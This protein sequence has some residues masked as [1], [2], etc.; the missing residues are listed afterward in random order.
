MVTVSL[1]NVLSF[2]K[3]LHF[4]LQGPAW[5]DPEDEVKQAFPPIY[6]LGNMLFAK[7]PSLDEKID[8]IS[9][10]VIDARFYQ[11]LAALQQKINEIRQGC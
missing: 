10:F 7:Q 11:D 1:A 8:E 2:R 4:D 9:T 5:I 3:K 6:V